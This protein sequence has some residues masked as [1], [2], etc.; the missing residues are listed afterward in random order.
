M[1]AMHEWEARVR[2]VEKNVND[3]WEFLRRLADQISKVQQDSQMG[4]PRPGQ[5]ARSARVAKNGGTPIPAMSGTTPGSG[6]VTLYDFDGEDLT[7]AETATAFNLHPSE[8]VSADA[9]LKVIRI[10]G[11]FFAFWEPCS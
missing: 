8:T 4:R 7:S 6:T 2:N 10:D 9:W 11:S 1:P 5:G 3:I